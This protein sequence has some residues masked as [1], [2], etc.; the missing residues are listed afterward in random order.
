MAR[1]EAVFTATDGRD[2]GKQFQLRE[3]SA[4]R[5][6]SWAIRMMLAMGKAG[7]EVPEALR[8]QGLAG[9][10][11]VLQNP[12]DD[13]AQFV[14]ALLGVLKVT[15]FTNMLRIDPE[16]ALPLLDE[17]MGCVQRIEQTVTRSLVED[18]IEEVST[19][20]K[21]R[22]AIWNLHTDFFSGAGPSTS[23]SVGPA[24]PASSSTIK[25]PPRRSAP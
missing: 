24:Q 4:T 9:L 22:T 6:E 16:D 13:G 2:A 20:L 7:I 14:A 11:S 17:M 10:M 15:L 3:M 21:L 19:R 5:A 23:A 25:A 18:D 12:D 8:Q 1:K